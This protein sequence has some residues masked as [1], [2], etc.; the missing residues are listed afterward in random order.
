MSFSSFYSVVNAIKDKSAEAMTTLS[1]DLQEFKSI[2]QE[3]VAELSKQMRPN[4]H[5]DRSSEE[6]SESE[7]HSESKINEQDNEEQKEE[8]EKDEEG[9]GTQSGTIGQD[10][11]L[12]TS[13]KNSFFSFRPLNAV[14]SSVQDSLNSV[15]G[16]LT[17]VGSKLTSLT[18]G[19]S[20]ESLEAMGSKLL[21]SAD[22]FLGSLAGEAPYEDEQELSGSAL[23]A[24]RFRLLAL[25]EDEK[26]YMEPPVDVKAFEKWKSEI[27][28]E[29]L[30]EVQKDVLDN[31]PTVGHKVTELVPLVVDADVFWT[32]YIYK[33]SLLAAQEM[34]G[35]DLLAQ[36][37]NEEEE[38]IGWD[39][40]SPKAKDDDGKPIFLDDESKEEE[41]TVPPG[42]GTNGPTSSSDGESWIEL[43]ERKESPSSGASSNLKEPNGVLADLKPDEGE[44]AAAVEDT[45]DWGD[46]DDLAVAEETTVDAVG[47]KVPEAV[48]AAHEDTGKRGEDWGEWD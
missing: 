34:R 44:E 21:N 42:S 15:Q 4:R 26:T 16:S 25:Q 35:A 8:E 38:E 43:N 41:E 13:L 20:L 18:V 24:R 10:V 37:L 19:G 1:S 40:D 32:H 31:Y 23:A 27:S 9:G 14:G 12:R 47:G 17:S 39:A 29:A 30:A 46:D 11:D 7:D 33:A 3:D 5:E 36:A 22:E 2:V 48:P 28:A 45:L 6:H